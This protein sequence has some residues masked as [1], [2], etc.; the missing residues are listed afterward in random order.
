MAST[1]LLTKF[2]RRKTPLTTA[3]ST[4]FL[5]SGGMPDSLNKPRNKIV[6]HPFQTGGPMSPYLHKA[7]KGGVLLRVNM[8]GVDQTQLKI[9]FENNDIFFEAEGQPEHPSERG[10]TYK[11]GF[12]L[13]GP[14]FKIAKIEPEMRNGI[15]RVFITV[16]AVDENALLESDCTAS[17]TTL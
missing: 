7:V 17:F 9:R 15:L 11:G 6:P 14:N 3:V 1:A 5:S 16:H 8:P 2:L 4:L 13:F 12:G 10:R